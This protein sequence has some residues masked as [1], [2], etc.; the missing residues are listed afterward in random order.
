MSASCFNFLQPSRPELFGLATMAE[1]YVYSDPASAAIKLRTFSE[2]LVKSIYAASKLPAAF[3]ATFVDLLENSAFQSITPTVIRDKLHAIRRE[4]NKAAHGDTV[5]AQTVIWILRE[6]HDLARWT[7]VNF[8]RA[9]PAGLPAF[10]AP[11]S[12]QE[13]KALRL[14]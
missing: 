5:T 3:R 14:K 4:G 12:P 8:E 1:S 13:N 10:E 9:D 6:A 2:S 7:V 11:K